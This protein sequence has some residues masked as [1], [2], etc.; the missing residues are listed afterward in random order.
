MTCFAFHPC[1]SPFSLSFVF[2]YS[3]G[4]LT[5]YFSALRTSLSA[6]QRPLPSLSGDFFP[7]LDNWGT[8]EFWSGYYTSRPFWKRM[9]RE[10]ESAVR[11]ADALFAFV[12]MRQAAATAPAAPGTPAD[13][14]P[15]RIAE[16]ATFR[17]R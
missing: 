14:P 7:Y 16:A 2:L 5:D 6:R 1:A 8:D 11:A 12:A 10:L 13:A 9:G 4:T 3:F 17:K 15:A